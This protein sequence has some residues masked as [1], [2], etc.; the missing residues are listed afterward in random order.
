MVGHRIGI[1]TPQFPL[2]RNLEEVI[3]HPVQGSLSPE[4]DIHKRKGQFGY[5]ILRILVKQSCM[6]HKNMILC[7]RDD[8]DH[9]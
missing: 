6:A 3:D 8:R 5:F 9:L 1:R 2:F 4:F 7:N